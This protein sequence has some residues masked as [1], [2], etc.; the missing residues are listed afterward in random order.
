MVHKTSLM[1]HH[2][3]KTAKKRGGGVM[4]KHVI[5]KANTFSVGRQDMRQRHSVWWQT[6]ELQ[7][8]HLAASRERKLVGGGGHPASH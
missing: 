4:G 7:A 5:S 8:G 6:G 1:G 2:L 3:I